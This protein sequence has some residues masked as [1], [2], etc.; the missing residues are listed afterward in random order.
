[1]ATGDKRVL[2]DVKHSDNSP[3][4]TCQPAKLQK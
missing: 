3:E 4:I 1:M 2:S